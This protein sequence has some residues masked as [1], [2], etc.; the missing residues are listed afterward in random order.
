[1]NY[2]LYK[3]VFRSFT[4]AFV[5]QMSSITIR[6]SVWLSSDED[7]IL[8]CFLEAPPHPS[9]SCVPCYPGNPSE[10]N[11][12][13]LWGKSSF[14]FDQIDK[15][16]KIF[17]WSWMVEGLGHWSCSPMA[18]VSHIIEID[19]QNLN[20]KVF[21]SSF[22]FSVCWGALGQQG[23]AQGKRLISLR[24]FAIYLQTFPWEWYSC[25]QGKPFF[26]SRMSSSGELAT[27]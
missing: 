22:H 12:D 21:C 6:I 9:Y 26:S 5:C 7:S 15:N 4:K 19:W 14:E 27:S 2:W 20:S 23:L 24:N 3:K 10:H 11:L 8:S 16:I 18:P 17:V 25:R 13:P 1:M